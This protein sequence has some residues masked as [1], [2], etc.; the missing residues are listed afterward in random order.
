MIYYGPKSK[1]PVVINIVEA[2]IHTFFI[3]FRLQAITICTIISAN[4]PIIRIYA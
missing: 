2:I 1:F 3:E 4:I